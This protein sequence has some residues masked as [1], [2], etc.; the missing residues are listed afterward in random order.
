MADTNG[1]QVNPVAA[2]LTGALI[3][4][5]IALVTTKIL[6]D[7]KMRD[8]IMDMASGAREKANMIFQGKMEKPMERV[9]HEISRMRGK[10]RSAGRGRSRSMGKPSTRT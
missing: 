5:G 10:K 4:A 9:S 3:G 7:Q 1:K 6:T 2:G 8:K